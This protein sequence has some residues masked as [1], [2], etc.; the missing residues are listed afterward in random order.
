MDCEVRT[1]TL[2][3]ARLYAYGANQGHGLRRSSEDKRKAV[4]G[5]LADFSD[6]SDSRIARHVGVS[7]K[8]VAAH[9]P[10]ILGNSEDAPDERT[11][12]TRHGTTAAMTLAGKRQQE[13]CALNTV[14]TQIFVAGPAFRGRTPS[15]RRHK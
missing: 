4:L 10:A 9:R 6:W 2:L 7:D 14:T 15:R 13:T 8:T 3:D 12:T 5:M 1:G 11:Y